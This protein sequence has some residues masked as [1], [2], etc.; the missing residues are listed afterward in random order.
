MKK[1]HLHLA[2][3]LCSAVAAAPA[4][5]DL[6]NVYYVAGY[7]AYIGGNCASAVPLLK[8]YTVQ[9]A[10]FLSKNPKLQTQLQAAINACIAFS[11]AAGGIATKMVAGGSGPPG[12]IKADGNVKSPD[13][14]Q[15]MSAPI[16]HA[17]DAM[18]KNTGDD[19]VLFQRERVLVKPAA[20]PD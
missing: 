18:K 3:A 9:D 12:A 6:T 14:L 2:I 1:A 13:M 19:P 11:G 8:T 7:N 5:A 10:D 16:L 15:Q 20:R 17:D 4:F